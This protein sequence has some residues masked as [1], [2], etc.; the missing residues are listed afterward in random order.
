MFFLLVEFYPVFQ[1]NDKPV[2][3]SPHKA[4]SNCVGY[5]FL[6]F[7]LLPFYN[8]GQNL[9]ARIFRPA[10]NRVDDLI[11]GLFPYLLAAARA[12]RM[13]GTGE[14][15]AVI[16]VNF[17]NR[18]DRRAGVAVRGFLFDGNCRRKPLDIIDIGLVH[19]A[20]KLAGIGRKGFHIAPL[21]FGKNRIECK[22]AFSRP[23]KPGNDD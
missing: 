7:A 21:P 12:V 3:S 11:N 20:Q 10:H 17:G 15:Q 19:S 8:R 16:I 22:R 1:I 4:R 23:R 5:D 9:N 14:Q 6:M 18:A 13:T 2:N